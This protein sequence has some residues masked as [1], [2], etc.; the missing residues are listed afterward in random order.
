ML[1]KIKKLFEKEGFFLEDEQTE[2]FNV[3]LK[4]LLKWN[5]V[6]N[7]TAIREPEEVI[8]RHFIDSVSLVRCFESINFEWKGKHFVDVGSGAGFPGVPLKIYLRDIKLTLV[9]AVAKKCAFL[10][11]IKI[12]IN[13]D[14]EVVCE[15]AEK[16]SRKFDVSLARALGKFED[17]KEI[18][19]SLAD[20]Y[21]FILKGSQLKE[22]WLKD[23]NFCRV[24]LSFVSESYILW[25][26]L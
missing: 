26:K 14:Y 11:Y 21:V 19:E 24:S 5:R 18:M 12:K 16:L 4:E 13:E 23:Y 17:V 22:E 10:E 9:E 20:E 6:H 3:Y 7:L 2:K 25:K 15:R 8:K 1:E